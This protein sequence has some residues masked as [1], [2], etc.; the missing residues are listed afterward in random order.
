MSKI[1]EMQTKDKVIELDLVDQA[2]LDLGFVRAVIDVLYE[3]SGSDH[4]D[5]IK[6][7]SIS[8]L[9]SESLAKIENLKKFID[10]ANRS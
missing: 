1:V 10:G 9:C 6:S 4:L 2:N 7:A 5:E 8:A 3:I